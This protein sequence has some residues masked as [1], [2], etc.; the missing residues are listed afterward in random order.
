LSGRLSPMGG[1][2]MAF[3]FEDRPADSPCVDTIWRTRSAGAGSFISRAVSQWEIVVTRQ[4]GK[5]TL[6]VRGPETRATPAPIPADAEFVGITF[7]LG[8]FLPCLP[9]GALVD[10]AVTLPEATSTSFWLQGAAWPFPDYD[11][12]DTFVER[13]VRRGLLVRDTLVEAAVRGHPPDRSARSVQRHVVRATGLTQG[14][15]GQIDRAR[16]AA[17]L[18]ERGVSIL[19]T[20]DQAGYADQPHLTTAL[21]RLIGQTPAQIVRQRRPE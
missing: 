6:T 1:T 4:E 18:L 17:A 20:V 5:T 12:A 15:I 7:A 13:L 14:A 21:R 19:D 16:R 3:I 10:R 8:A 11:T 9:L 2:G